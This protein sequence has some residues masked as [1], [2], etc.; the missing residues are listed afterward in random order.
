MTDELSENYYSYN[1]NNQSPVAICRSPNLAG[2]T[3]DQKRSP[4]LKYP[5]SLA[6]GATWFGA[7]QQVHEDYGGFYLSNGEVLRR[8]AMRVHSGHGNL[9]PGQV[10]C[11]ARLDLQLSPAQIVGC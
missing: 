8:G 1:N 6:L 5:T 2:G 7:G 10:H 4:G 3:N 11:R 9:K